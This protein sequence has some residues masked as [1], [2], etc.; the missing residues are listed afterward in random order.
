MSRN[1]PENLYS[2]ASHSFEAIEMPKF[3]E[4]R[5]KDWVLFGKDNLYPQKLIEL[6]QSSAI[7]HTAINAKLSGHR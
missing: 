5:S 2:L 7:H 1:I 3:S 4:S 6:Y